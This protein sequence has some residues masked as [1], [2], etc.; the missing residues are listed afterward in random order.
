MAEE[1]ICV[2]G[3]S[4]FVGSHVTAELLSRGYSVNGTLREASGPKAGWLTEQL[5]P[6]AKPERKLTL[7]SAELGDK[8]S[9]LSAM[10]GCSGVIMC[11]GAERQ[12]STTVELMVGG[13]ENILDAAL[14]VG[15]G[16]AVF[17]SS[18]GSTNPP[19][20][21]PVLKNEVDHWSD[22]EQQIAAGKYSPAAKTLMDRTVLARMEASNGS[23]RVCVFNPS[24]I[25]TELKVTSK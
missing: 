20:G 8:A 24:M 3:C 6:L 4:G 21:D 5:A 19:S 18:T 2:V 10:Q 7:F 15:I 13:A 17:T 11:A 12:D 14:E 1:T 25:P 9:L 22:P 23:L 16:R